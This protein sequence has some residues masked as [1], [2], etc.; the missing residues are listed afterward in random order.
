[1]WPEVFYPSPGD[2]HRFLKQELLTIIDIPVA[3][4]HEWVIDLASNKETLSASLRLVIVG[5]ER[6]VPQWLGPWKALAGDRVRWANAYGPTETTITSLVYEVDVT[7]FDGAPGVVPI[8]RPIAGTQAY[9]LDGQMSPVPIGVAGDLY[10]AGV[11]LARGYLNRPDLTAE[12]FVPHCFATEPGTRL[13]RTGDRARY[14]PG[15]NIDF[16]GRDD[17]QI[18]V[19]GF[20]IEPGEIECKLRHHPMVQDV[21]VHVSEDTAGDK[22][23]IAYIISHPGETLTRT[24]L[25]TFVKN[26][27]PE[28]M[29]PAAFVFLAT[30]PYTRNNKI[31]YRKLPMPM[32]EKSDEETEN[33]VGPKNPI[34]ELLVDIWADVLA[35]EDIGVYDNFF[36]LG[37]HSLKGVRVISR[38]RNAFQLELPL[39]ILF[40]EPTVKGL[41]RYIES[42]QQKSARQLDHAIV[43]VSR[44]KNLPLSFAQ[45]RLWFLSQLTEHDASYNLPVVLRFV[46]QLHFAALKQ[47]IYELIRRHEVL[48]S[49][50]LAVER[51]LLQRITPFSQV[52]LDLPLIDLSAWPEAQRA[53]E[54][55][56]LMR[57]EIERPFA[58]TRGSL[59]F[60]YPLS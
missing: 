21:L 8:G 13:Y 16:L 45:E 30:F 7:T 19:R 23:I 25:H 42:Q 9:I 60:T 41:A 4:W 44:E 54:V 31:D 58:L 47:S 52:A 50:I 26:S 11:S 55:K 46:G 2:F 43:P 17:Q 32:P 53:V 49:S 10:L 33:G 28:Y 18:K 14:L 59:V 57:E 15:G 29:I 34:E 51:Q 39:R 20:R 27:L 5:G 3:Y 36:A 37:G 48:R 40:D 56:R 38:V 6:T 24:A 22:Q 12:R 1:M 35:Q